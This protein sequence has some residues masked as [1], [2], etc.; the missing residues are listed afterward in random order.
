MQKSS[1][2]FV[3]KLYRYLVVSLVQV[4]LGKEGRPAQPVN[5]I[6]NAWDGISIYICGFVEHVVVN[7][8]PNCTLFLMKESTSALKGLD[9]GHIH[10][11]V[12]YSFSYLQIF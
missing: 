6:F 5:S 7:A 8:H 11:K 10:P 2:I 4:Y 1:F 12:K 3:P 9:E